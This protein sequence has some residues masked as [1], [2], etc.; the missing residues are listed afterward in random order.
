VSSSCCWRPVARRGGRAELG[1]RLGGVAR[2]EESQRRKA[3]AVTS[4]EATHR[5][6]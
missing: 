5:S 2:A 6:Y 3:R 4:L 1:Q